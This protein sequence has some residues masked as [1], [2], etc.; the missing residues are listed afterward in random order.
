MFQGVD[1]GDWPGQ[2]RADCFQHQISL[3]ERLADE[4]EI[5]LFEIAEAAVEQLRRSTRGARRV[6]SLLD[7]AD[8]QTTACRVKGGTA[9]R[10]ASTYHQYV[11]W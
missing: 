3:A 9:P 5:E 2:V 1:E 7:E 11:E 8:S 10:H 6:I 4:T